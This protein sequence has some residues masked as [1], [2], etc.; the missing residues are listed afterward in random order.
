[1]PYGLCPATG[2]GMKATGVE[3]VP[4][5]QHP[6]P[7]HRDRSLATAMVLQAI[8]IGSKPP[9]HQWKFFRAGGFD[10]VQLDRG[11][12]FVNLR[13]L[14]QKLWVALACP[15]AGL[16][17]DA[18]T[19]TLID[20]NKDGRIR[21]QELI[22]AV[23]WTLVRLKQPDDLLRDLKSLPLDSIN[24]AAPEGKAIL[25]SAKQILANLGK[26]GA[27]CITLGDTAD[28][29]KIF[30]QTAF[31]GDGVIVEDSAGDETAK[32][33]VRD[34]IA[35]IGSAQDRSSKPGIDKDRMEKFFAEAA[36]FDMWQRI[37]ES[38]P[39]S[40]LPLGTGTAA[41]AG[42]MQAV[43]AKIDDY[44]GRCRLAAFDP[45]ALA[46][47]NREEKEYITLAAKDISITA[48]EVSSF[49]L[50]MVTAGKPLPLGRGINPAWE[51]AVAAFNQLA[52]TPLLG[53][54]VE[55]TEFD[56]ATI[57]QKLAPFEAWQKAKAGAAVEKLGIA[58]V[59][60]ILASSAKAQL[61]TAIAHDKE[62]EGKANAIADVD[63]LI[64]YVSNLRLLCTN[65]VNFKDFYDLGDPAIFQ[66][67]TL[68]L[69]QRSCHLCLSVE[70]ASRHAAM[71]ALAGSYLTYVDCVRKGTGEKR[72]I[73]AAFTD[74]DSDNLM[75]GRNGVFYDRKG[76]DWDATITKII[77]NP[78]SLRQA[79]WSPYKKL[80]RLIEEEVAKRAAAAETS[81]NAKLAKAAEAT[82]N[83]D[84]LAPKPVEKPKVD[85]GMVAALSVAFGSIG[86]AVAYVLGLLKGI[87]LLQLLLGVAGLAL[88][89]SGP[90]M[91]LAYI[92]LRKR[93][94]GPILD[95]NGWAVNSKARI[96]V[97]FGTSLTDV[98]KLPVGA[99]RDLTDPFAEKANPWPKLLGFGLVLYLIYY[100]LNGMGYINE[101]TNGR[102]GTPKERPAAAAAG[103]ARGAGATASVS[104]TTTG[105]NVNV[106]VTGAAQGQ[107]QT[108][109]ATS[110][111]PAAPK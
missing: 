7:V 39:D 95:A 111:P 4:S 92:K 86:T 81:A 68:Y 1:M 45:R 71:A 31:N 12:D 80:V 10:Q 83:A 15:T 19:L 96:N 47:L 33:V 97:P 63:K 104:A 108:Q 60:E 89:I 51:S 44:F 70:D 78:I 11:A 106:T 17:F 94:L 18:K 77:D 41:A 21:V 13:K 52:V 32:Q 55:L 69:D 84:R 23:E 49:P 16:E 76:Q 91:I 43:R 34:I 79:F 5:V 40:V 54:R 38:A 42:A 98:A 74:G 90:S 100:A 110:A 73:V 59:R 85:V 61:E 58:R 99:L 53:E 14:D 22:A 65:F 37:A 57:N 29:A 101:W 8:G 102:L 107:G 67:G 103:H 66:V 28:T 2:M 50:A 87:T 109:G 82:A 3:P 25:L 93:S 48:Q 46:A 36:A 27:D 6:A 62:E 64:R 35:C 56:W 75:V 72:Q 26:S 30:A 105:T 24:D 88:L 9:E 20:T